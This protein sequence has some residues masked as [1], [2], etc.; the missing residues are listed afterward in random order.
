MYKTILTNIKK[1]YLKARLVHGDLSEYN[2]MNERGKPVIF[3][4][5]QSVLIGHPMAHELLLRDFKNLN[6]YF[7]KIGVP[8]KDV[9]YL[10]K[11]VTGHE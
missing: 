4:M 2:I 11:W 9:N 1:L 8:T 10:V 7:F 3:D 5:G 6:N